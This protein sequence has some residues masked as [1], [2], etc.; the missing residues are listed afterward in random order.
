MMIKV[1]A[2][3]LLFAATLAAQSTD[4]SGTWVAKAQGPMGEMEI[5][6]RLNVENGKITGTQTLPFGDAP[7]I[8][9]KIEGDQVEMT[10]EMEFFG[11]IQRRTVTAKIVGDELHVTP[12]MPGPPPGGGPAE[13]CSSLGERRASPRSRGE[14]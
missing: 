7:I 5:V 4:V 12:A 3:V 10:V 14:D 13:V 2:V 6:Y 1:V 8:D 9:G 11:N